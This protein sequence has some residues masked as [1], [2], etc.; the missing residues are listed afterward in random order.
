MIIEE[1]TKQSDEI[2]APTGKNEKSTFFTC[3][4]YKMYRVE[5]GNLKRFTYTYKITI[6]VSMWN[7]RLFCKKLYSATANT[8]YTTTQLQDLSSSLVFVDARV[9][10]LDSVW[11]VFR[12]CPFRQYLRKFESKKNPFA[13][14]VTHNCD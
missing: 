6:F 1:K 4:R 14:Y 7:L 8:A 5:A 11:V 2:K 3:P 12:S 13:H 9:V 10:R